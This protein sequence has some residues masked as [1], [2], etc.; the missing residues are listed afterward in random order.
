MEEF[1]HINVDV[2]YVEAMAGGRIDLCAREAVQLAMQENKQVVL[3][4]ND[5]EY[6]IDPASILPAILKQHS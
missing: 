5:R 4:H 2:I 6:R 3:V 1:K